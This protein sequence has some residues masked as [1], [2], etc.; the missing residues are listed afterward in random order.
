MRQI[1][2][3]AIIL[4]RTNY[5]EADRIVTF[6]TPAGKLKALVK[7]VRRSK[8]K[9][10]GGIEL[11]SE[12]SVTFMETRGDL[13]RIISTRLIHHYQEIVGD[14]QRMMV[15]YE[16][17][18]LLDGIIEDE[19]EGEYYELLK[20][21]LNALA[22]LEIPLYAV[23]VWFYTRLLRL[24]GHG[25][26]LKTDSEGSVLEDDGLYNFSPEHMCFNAGSN[27]QYRAEHI[28]LLRL[29]IAQPAKVLKQVKDISELSKTLNPLVKQLVVSHNQS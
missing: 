27:G 23:E 11:F 13:A 3:P 8:S 24:H 26:N 19:A 10:A 29:C 2:T 21:V 15:G 17:M 6:L 16:F 20:S 12:S 25:L 1:T 9:L 28:K 18:K 14:L 22:D 4:R 5:G 7:G